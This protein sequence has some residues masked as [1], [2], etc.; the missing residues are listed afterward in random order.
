LTYTKS[1]REVEPRS[2]IEILIRHFTDSPDKKQERQA[3]ADAKDHQLLMAAARSRDARDYSVIR[4]RIAQDFYR[5]AGAPEAEV[6]PNLN[7]EQIAE[8]T[9]Y[10]ET[11]PYLSASRKEFR[12]A[13]G[14]AEQRL[15]QREAEAVRREPQQT[16]T[17]E[18]AGRQ[19]AEQKQ[20][21]TISTKIE[22]SGG[23]S[24]RGR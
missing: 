4:D 7:R 9:A 19:P 12:E 18:L 6:A 14:A 3:V 21:D 11:L 10:A 16:R 20:H 15:M 5:A 17:T 1:V 22:R 8:L 2:A 23:G 24:F 13:A